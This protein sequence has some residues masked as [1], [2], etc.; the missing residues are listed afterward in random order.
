[1]TYYTYND[2]YTPPFPILDISL[3]TPG[4]EATL[5]P[6]EALIDT[7]ADATLI[8]TMYLEQVYAEEVDRAN[9][10]GQWGER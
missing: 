7:G 5:G 6:L 4:A 1:M 9:V 8:P 3:G 2:S 10:R